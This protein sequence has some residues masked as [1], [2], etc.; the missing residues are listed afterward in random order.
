[1]LVICPHCNKKHTIDEKKI[2]ANATKARCTTC[3]KSFALNIK[4]SVHLYFVHIDLDVP[5]L[6]VY[7]ACSADVAC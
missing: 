7:V 6:Y 1:M 2:P 4:R 5:I 3:G